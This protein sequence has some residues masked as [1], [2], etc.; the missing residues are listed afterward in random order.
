MGHP[1]FQQTKK[2]FERLF[3]KNTKA[4]P[5]KSCKRKVKNGVSK[6]TKTSSAQVRQRRLMF[7][8]S[9]DEQ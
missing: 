7:E 5:K 3:K 4:V 6:P 1:H 8:E 2:T 9:S